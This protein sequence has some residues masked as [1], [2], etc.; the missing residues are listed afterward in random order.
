MSEKNMTET[1][2]SLE[3]EVVLLKRELKNILDLLKGGTAIPPKVSELTMR[4]LDKEGRCDRKE[5]L[6]TQVQNVRVDA[7]YF[8]FTPECKVFNLLTLSDKFVQRLSDIEE[9]IKNL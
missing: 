7:E 4:V 8:K 9:K 3:K 5:A 1:V 6:E 2:I